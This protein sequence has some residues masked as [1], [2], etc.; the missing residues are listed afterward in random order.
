MITNYKHPDIGVFPMTMENLQLPL[1][2]GEDQLAL[3]DHQPPRKSRRQ[4]RQN[5]CIHSFCGK[6]LGRKYAKV[7]VLN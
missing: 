5:R 6:K 2:R 4:G 1:S 3:E 7:R